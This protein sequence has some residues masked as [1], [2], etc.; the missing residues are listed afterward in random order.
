[1]PLLKKQWSPLWGIWKIEESWEE[2]LH[3]LERREAYLPLLNRYQ[4]ESR[5]TEWLSVRTLLKELTGSETMIA[6]HENG[7]PYLPDSE[8]HISI[9]HTKG[10]AALLLSPHKPAGIDIEYCSERVHRVK[11]RFL[12]AAEFK[13]LGAHLSTHTLLVCWSAKET[14]FKMIEQQTADIQNDI[15]IV[16]YSP[17]Q[18]NG[19]IKVQE[20][21]TS[22]SSVFQ[23]AYTITPD[24]VVTHSL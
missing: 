14:A 19:T 18:E 4:S 12:S 8:L 15:Q 7:V 20:T 16:D 2:L 10:Y 13:L 24:F 17:S 3:R 9:S 23:I 1:M 6:Y 21:L 11:S 22:Q 5:K